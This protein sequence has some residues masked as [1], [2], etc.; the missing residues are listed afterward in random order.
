[1]SLDSNM[2]LEI[3]AEDATY[4]ETPFKKPFKGH[5]EIKKYWEEIVRVKERDVKFY[6][7][8]LYVDGDIGIAEWYTIF[9]RT[10]NGNKEELKG[11]IIAEVSEEKITRLW[12]YWVKQEKPKE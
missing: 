7:E 1:M 11:V 2:I 9:I 8:N 10:D 5:S 3:F 12:E 6:V 4:Q